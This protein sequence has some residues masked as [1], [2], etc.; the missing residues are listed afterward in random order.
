MNKTD[1]ARLDHMLALAT[2]WIDGG[3]YSEALNCLSE[4]RAICRRSKTV[5][6]K[7]R[8]AKV[9]VAMQALYP[10]A[11]QRRISNQ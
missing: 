1:K 5:S 2:L 8:A 11:V 6:D 3:M 4:A 9:V 7:A 10:L